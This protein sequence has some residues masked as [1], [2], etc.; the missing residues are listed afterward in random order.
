MV[1][2]FPETKTGMI[3]DYLVSRGNEEIEVES[4][5]KDL[6]MDKKTVASI[7]SRL[8]SRGAIT[9]TSRGV[10]VH[11]QESVKESTVSDILDKLE[12]TIGRTFGKQILEKTQ[13]EGIAD[14]KSIESLEEAL[15]RTRKIIG[16]KGA[17][18]IFKLVSKNVA[19]SS[20]SKYLL[21]RLGILR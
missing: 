8:V 13:I 6:R 17:D 14:R 12:T 15:R 18:G 21:T 11:K 10:Y 9:R 1:N 3:L 19:A 4:I 16:S 7:A 5:A 2:T 20:E